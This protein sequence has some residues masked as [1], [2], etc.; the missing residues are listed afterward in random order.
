MVD[1][2][3]KWLVEASA[4]EGLLLVLED[5]H[6]ADPLS[7][8]LLRYMLPRL[9][10]APIMLI[11]TYRDTDL[12]AD[13]LLWALLPDLERAGATHVRLP[14][15][16]LPAVRSLVEAA[17]PECAAPGELAGQLHSR[18]GGHP[19]FVTQLLSLAA[20]TGGTAPLP[21]TIQ[22]ALQRRL[23]SLTPATYAV[24]QAA[25]VIGERFAYDLLVRV[26]P[27]TE[28]ETLAALE[29]ALAARVI[30]SEGAERFVF[31]HA[32]VREVLEAGLIGLRRR[33]LHLAAAEALQA[34][35]G[36]D[37]GALAYHL[38]AAGDPRAADALRAALDRA[39]RLGALAQA[40]RWGQELVDQLPEGDPRLPEALL[41]LGYALRYADGARSRA[42]WEG[43][44]ERGDRVVAAWA[45]HMLA[46]SDYGA[47]TPG[48]VEKLAAVRREEEE[49]LDDP[50]FR[51]LQVD[52]TGE[53]T[54]HAPINR[55]LCSALTM[56]GRLERA[57][58]LIATMRSKLPPDQQAG[59][60]DQ[61]ANVAMYDGRVDL[62]IGLY[63]R[64]ARTAAERWRDYRMAFL[65]KWTE[66]VALLWA[67][68]DQPDELDR[69]AAEVA[70]YEA[71]SRERTG[72]NWMPEGYSSLGFFHFVRGDWEAARHNLTTYLDQHPHASDRSWWRYYAA[73]LHLAE[74][75]VK[76]AERVMAPV[77]P[78][79]P[80]DDLGFERISLYARTLRARICI[81]AGELAAARA[82]LEAADR[83]LQT[84]EV[85]S[86]RGEL[87]QRWAE[88]HWAAGDSRA[89]LQNASAALAFAQ[90]ANDL[91]HAIEAHRLLGQLHA[92]CGAADASRE[93]FAAGA[94]LAQACRFP[95]EWALTCV[96]WA[97]ALPQVTRPSTEA[98]ETLARLRAAPALA[99][100]DALL[101]P[102]RPDGLTQRELEIVA[103]VAQ[104][105]K[106]KEIAA[107][108]FI[109]VKTVQAHLR[110]IFNRLDVA[111][112]A[113]LVAYAARHGLVR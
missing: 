29:E 36:A 10:T 9:R 60:D 15:L 33:R 23:Q 102:G 88:Y 12:R 109:S 39:L 64:A 80:K 41:K 34:Q 110:N 55:T 107:A 87:H 94:R 28:E 79:R 103:L 95:Y 84:R 31:D 66:L 78:R 73:L 49:L 26:A 3:F 99:R 1:P 105:Q 61:E 18:T 111:N 16:D 72:L 22:Q 54:G 89:A 93:H 40:A 92:G 44:L 76:G 5:V 63:E 37:P 69:V 35:P 106:D 59:P 51:R 67:R 96:A 97:E 8:E 85:V 50:E 53:I 112:R 38:G 82:W 57:R 58:G 62:A 70:T 13:E 101:A 43:A 46:W 11:V 77:T 17:L 48:C 14:R 68:A 86:L 90:N 113:A 32:L 7:L 98:R 56:A 74:G 27:G 30:R 4:G 21:E 71:E 65:Y 75:D 91:W 83:D 45:R 25:A 6:W 100:A 24:L 47:R 104:G 108:L 20:K 81:A 19:L 42:C 2:L 52:L